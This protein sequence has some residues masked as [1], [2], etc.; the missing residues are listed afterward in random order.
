MHRLAGADDPSYQ[1]AAPALRIEV[2]NS[3]SKYRTNDMG[4]AAEQSVIGIAVGTK[5][6]GLLLAGALGAIVA[7]ALTP[8]KSRAE[9]MGM[10]AASFASS[11]FVGPLVIEY[12]ALTHYG[13]Q[14]QLGIC[15][16]VAAP[17]W[18]GWCVVSRQFERWRNARNPISTIRKDVKR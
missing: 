17:A 9:L 1:P 10:L 12:L 11:L 13:F 7:M 18:L 3:M 15:F 6:G 2:Q 8:P 16:M 4:G 14:A 5:V